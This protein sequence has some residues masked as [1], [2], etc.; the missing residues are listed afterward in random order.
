[1]TGDLE[2]VR[3]Q[4]RGELRKRGDTSG[5]EETELQSPSEPVPINGNAELS[6]T[7]AE[8]DIVLADFHADWCGPCRMLEP[9]IETIAAETDD[10][11]VFRRPAGR[12]ARR[13]AGRSAAPLCD[14]EAQV[15]RP[16]CD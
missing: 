7:I 4:K 13:H 10:R 16:R 14:R 15:T 9:V 12:T 6:G 2:E 11:S 8:H 3:R 5:D 1:M